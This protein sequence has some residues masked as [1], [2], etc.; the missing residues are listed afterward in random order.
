MNSKK[1]KE[2][3]TIEGE[4]KGGVEKHKTRQDKT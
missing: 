3:E 1:E 2:K 4:K